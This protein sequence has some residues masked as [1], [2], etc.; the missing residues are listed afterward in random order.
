MDE[1]TW[2]CTWTTGGRDPELADGCDQVALFLQAGK[3]VCND[4]LDPDLEAVVMGYGD[5]P[6]V[7]T[8][9]QV[10]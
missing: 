9:D 3:L 6:E 2:T 7:D 1:L 4:H 10:V 8:V 5:G